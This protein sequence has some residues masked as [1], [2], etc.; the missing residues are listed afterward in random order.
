ME[1][2]SGR[3]DDRCMDPT[4]WLMV[5]G[6]SLANNLDNT[7]VGLA[8]G[9]GGIRLPALVNLWI[10]L[11]TFAITGAAALV[12][13]RA[14]LLIPAAQSRMLS[15][16]ILCAIGAYVLRGGLATRGE[17]P[18]S[19]L[20]DPTLADIDGSRH[21]DFKEGALLGVAL[22]INNLGGGVSA[23][24]LH[25]SVFWTAFFSAAISYLVLWLGGAVGRRM[26]APMIA[27]RGPIVAGALLIGIG[28][29][30]FR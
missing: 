1:G 27:E 5:L 13:D 2:A 14:A 4:G 25:L 15:A 23:G 12:G 7:G 29:L 30:Q 21:I 28:L 11:I 24:L 16:L 10:S 3:G 19:V 18:R 22:S 17:R 20:D 26:A 8:Y 6:L 9:A